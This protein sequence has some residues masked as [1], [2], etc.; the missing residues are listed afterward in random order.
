M[1]APPPPPLPDKLPPVIS[2]PAKSNANNNNVQIANAIRPVM[3]RRIN[4]E[5]QTKAKQPSLSESCELIHDESS[6]HKS[7]CKLSF[8]SDDLRQIFM[9]LLQNGEK[10]KN[11][12]ALPLD[13]QV[14]FVLI[15]SNLCRCIYCTF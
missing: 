7:V 14:S 11:S 15:A 13:Q 9:K 12:L 10:P 4:L 8:G 2:T 1:A 5:L 6:E 3:T